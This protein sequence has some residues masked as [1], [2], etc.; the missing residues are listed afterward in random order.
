MHLFADPVACCCML[1]SCCTKFESIKAKLRFSF[2]HICLPFYSLKQ[3]SKTQRPRKTENL[4]FDQKYK[5]KVNKHRR[6]LYVVYNC[7][8][9]LGGFARHEFIIYKSLIGNDLNLSDTSHSGV[10]NTQ[11]TKQNNRQLLPSKQRLLFRSVMKCNYQ[12]FPHFSSHSDNGDYLQGR[13]L[14]KFPDD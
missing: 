14:Q 6:K 4:V 12:Y 11:S 2:L 3:A 7:V 13:R 5:P 9:A 1:L 10:M 8:L